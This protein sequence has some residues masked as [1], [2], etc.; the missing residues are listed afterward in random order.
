MQHRVVNHLDITK[1]IISPI[2]AAT[3]K[4]FDKPKDIEEAVGLLM[5]KGEIEKDIAA[6]KGSELKQNAKIW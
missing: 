4:R 2:I 1:D 6:G 5:A 3:S